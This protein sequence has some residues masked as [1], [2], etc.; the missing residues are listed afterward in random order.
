MK[1]S[2]LVLCCLTTMT[3]YIFITSWL[4][5]FLFKTLFKKF[6]NE[7][8]ESMTEYKMY[9]E[10]PLKTNIFSPNYACLTIKNVHPCVRRLKR[11]KLC[12]TTLKTKQWDAESPCT[13]KIILFPWSTLRTHEF[14]SQIVIV[15]F[16]STFECWQIRTHNLTAYQQMRKFIRSFAWTHRTLSQNCY[17]SVNLTARI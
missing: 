12:D 5:N 14:H 1:I 7:R 8:A 9:T 6:S 13:E 11:W 15:S 3:F 16:N 2:A 10:L 17:I 4:S